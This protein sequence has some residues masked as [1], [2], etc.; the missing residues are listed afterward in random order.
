[1]MEPRIARAVTSAKRFPDPEMSRSHLDN[2]KTLPC[3]ICG[4]EPA[5]D[6]HHLKRAAGQG[7]KSL[8]QKNK[9]RYAVPL[10]RTHHDEAEDGDDEAYFTRHGID[11]RSVAM[12]LWTKRKDRVAMVRIAERAKASPDMR[13]R[14]R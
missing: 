8:S 3:L 13:I 14:E 9:D 2:V 11:A 1:M 5:G 12:A 10:C 6:P 7:P 4:V